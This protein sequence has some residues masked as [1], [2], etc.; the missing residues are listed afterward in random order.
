MRLAGLDFCTWFGFN[1]GAACL[2]RLR[3]LRMD[4]MHKSL[5]SRVPLQPL[6]YLSK[7][8]IA[9]L[10]CSLLV[11]WE[12]QLTC[13]NMPAL[14]VDVLTAYITLDTLTGR[15]CSWDGNA[16]SWGFNLFFL[17]NGF[18]SKRTPQVPYVCLFAWLCFSMFFI[19]AGFF[20]DYRSLA[21][22]WLTLLT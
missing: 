13:V 2:S 15:E 16:K 12:Q 6:P 14:P 19:F 20:V 1:E 4:W 17:T 18:E 10:L 3:L 11:L 9:C 21:I 5:N 22:Y 8:N 7:V